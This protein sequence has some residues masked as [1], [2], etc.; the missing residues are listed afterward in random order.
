[1]KSGFAARSA[2]R[3]GDRSSAEGEESFGARW[4]GLT[5]VALVVAPREA[6]RKGTTDAGSRVLATL[7]GSAGS[8][9]WPQKGRAT[10]SS[11]PNEARSPRLVA[12]ALRKGCWFTGRRCHPSVACVR[13]LHGSRGNTFRFVVCRSSI[14]SATALQPA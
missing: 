10:S 8:P 11:R 1:M 6:S 13:V 2:P 14:Q 7:V 4:N 5:N 12:L 3:G 9:A